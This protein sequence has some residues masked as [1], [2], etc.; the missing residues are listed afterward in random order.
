MLIKV[1][2]PEGFTA[3]GLFVEPKKSP[4]IWGHIV[5]FSPKVRN[6]IHVSITPGDLVL[7]H[8]YAQDDILTTRGTTISMVHVKS[9]QALFTPPLVEMNTSA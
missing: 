6:Y 9:I 4:P 3:S 5:A 2:R 8:R 1:Y 7:F